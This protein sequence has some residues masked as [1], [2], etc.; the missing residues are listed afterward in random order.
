MPYR[1]FD[2]A[3]PAEHGER[4]G[5]A[6]KLESSV[7]L[8]RFPG[9]VCL[10]AWHLEE[11]EPVL[12]NAETVVHAASTIKTLVMITALQQVQAGRLALD[13]EVP[14]PAERPGGAGVLAELTSVHRLSLADLLRLM[15]VI[16]DNTA[17]NAVIDVVGFPAI[18]RCAE[19]LG[20]TA[21]RVERRLMEVSAPGRIET[22]ALDQARVFDALATGRALTTELTGFALDVLRRQQVRD[23]LPALLPREAGCWHKT[24]EI[25]G[26]RHD[27]GLIG[28]SRPQ[29]VVAVLVDQLTDERSTADH[30]GGPACELIA[31]IG[32]AAFDALPG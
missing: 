6:E 1:W 3:Q 14:L 28:G 11:R 8:S 5:F 4:V 20:C 9:R 13:A 2:H 19:Q 21:T 32:R 16:S 24:G 22:T 15:I 17:A 25:S 23:R 10:A 12:V 27:V 29:A 18:R 31:R 26:V 7:D 30:R